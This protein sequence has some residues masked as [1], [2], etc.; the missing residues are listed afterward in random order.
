MFYNRS[1]HGSALRSIYG[2]YELTFDKNLGSNGSFIIHYYNIQTLC[3]E[4]CK[5]CENLPKAVSSDLFT[6][7]NMKQQTHATNFTEED[8]KNRI[9]GLINENK[10]VKNKTAA[11]LDSFFVT[12]FAKEI[13]IEIDTEPILI[14][15]QTPEMCK[16][17]TQTKDS[18]IDVSHP[19][20]LIWVL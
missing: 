3:I 14:A 7:N 15:Q 20:K 13:F 8:I 12:S 9:E 1:T 11:G 4:L 16:V 17:S 5:V 2:D 18:N 19:W 6:R 10:L